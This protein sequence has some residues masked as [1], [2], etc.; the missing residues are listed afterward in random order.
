M[1]LKY[2]L[3]PRVLSEEPPAY[4]RMLKAY[5]GA[6]LEDLLQSKVTH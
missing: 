3:P 4:F 2:F 5:K 1:G 6:D